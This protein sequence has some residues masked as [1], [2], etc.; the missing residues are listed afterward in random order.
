MA[1]MAKK[2]KAGRSRRRS[3]VRDL[4][5]KRAGALEGGLSSLSAPTPIRL[6]PG[7]GPVP[8]PFPNVQWKW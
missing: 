3:A 6:D 4:S 8:I 1:K 2:G 7:P 5:A